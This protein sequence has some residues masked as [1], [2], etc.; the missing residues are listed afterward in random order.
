MKKFLLVFGFFLASSLVFSFSNSVKAAVVC[1][2]NGSESSD[3]T[4]PDNWDIIAGCPGAPTVDNYDV[5]FPLSASN[6]TITNVP[7][8]LIIQSM[9]L[10]GNYNI[11]GTTAYIVNGVTS[12]SNFAQINIDL[13]LNGNQ[14]FGPAYYSDINLNGFDLDFDSSIAGITLNGVI[15]GEGDI[16]VTNTENH[17]VIFIH[18]NTF[19][20]NIDIYSNGVTITGNGGFGNITN[21]ITMHPGAGYLFVV[22]NIDIPQSIVLYEDTGIDNVWGNNALS[23]TIITAGNS[24]TFGAEDGTLTISGSLMGTYNTTFGDGINF[25]GD[26]AFYHGILTIVGSSRI[27]GLI[28]AEVNLVSNGTLWGTGTLGTLNAISGTIAPGNSP[29]II[30]I[31]GDM[32]LSASDNVNF[33]I[34][35]TTPGTGYDQIQV[36]GSTNLNGATLGLALGYSPT[37]GT[38]FNLI[39]SPGGITGTFA[40][41]PNGSLID[42]GG[43][44]YI[45]EYTETQVNLGTVGGIVTSE[46]SNIIIN[47]TNPTSGQTVTITVVVGTN[48]LTP[49]GTVELFDGEISLGTAN[50][51]AGNAVFTISNFSAGSHSLTAVYSGDLQHDEATS[52]PYSLIVNNPILADTGA[53][54]PTSAI[55]L[56]MLISIAGIKFTGKMIN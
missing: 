50:V 55:I 24:S 54:I 40:G 41:L 56:I 44:D 3:W 19:S 2:W 32:I 22:G 15:S 31:N 29:G 43:Q 10:D 34:I 16:T 4:D 37:G 42:I 27:N 23:G 1:N 13:I 5:V 52:E 17:P 21:L 12:T 18:Q 51:V 11:T 46:I 48:F 53:S 9:T 28:A 25:A 36:T 33:E 26:G 39:N 6:K 47:P 14:T 35:G 7:D 45:I 20:G 49:T 30:N 8:S 38:V